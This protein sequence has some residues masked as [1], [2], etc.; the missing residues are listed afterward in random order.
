M[1]CTAV[2]VLFG[3]EVWSRVVFGTPPLRSVSGARGPILIFRPGSIV[4]YAVAR[5]RRSSLFIF[6]TARDGEKAGTQIAGVAPTVGLFLASQ[7]QSVI[8]KADNVCTWLATTGHE[9]ESLPDAFWLRAAAFVA[10]GKRRWSAFDPSSLL[11]K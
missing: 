9:P 2:Q 3:P 1:S 8:R 11:P 5:G 6:R 7:R 4:A 10:D